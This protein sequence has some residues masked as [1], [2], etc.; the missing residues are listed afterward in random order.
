MVPHLI[1]Q[2]TKTGLFLNHNFK[3]SFSCM[4]SI[5][6]TERTFRFSLSAPFLPGSNLICAYR[7]TTVDLNSKLKCRIYVTFSI[8]N[9]FESYFGADAVGHLSVA[10]SGC[11]CSF[12]TMLNFNFKLVNKRTEMHDAMHYYL[13]S[14]RIFNDSLD[15]E[16]RAMPS[17]NCY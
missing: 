9:Q 13:T 6:V 8:V 12:S 3:A 14:L 10:I 17:Q 1:Q 2:L 4:S 15:K 16:L 5:L 11:F 7:E